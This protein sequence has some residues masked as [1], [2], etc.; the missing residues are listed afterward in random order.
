MSGFENRLERFGHPSPKRYQIILA[1]LLIQLLS[2]WT[3]SNAADG[4]SLQLQLQLR[5]RV[6]LPVGVEREDVIC[7]L[8]ERFSNRLF[9]FDVT[10]IERST[11]LRFETRS[12]GMSHR[13]AIVVRT[14]D[15]KWKGSWICRQDQ[16]LSSSKEEIVLEL[17][18]VQL[19]PVQIAYQSRP[20]PGATLL[21]DDEFYHE[22]L[23]AK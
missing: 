12:R 19:T 1:L 7:E 16:L 13:T 23:M 15:G 9:D 5:G 10:P 14:L 2:P 22:P 20:Q 21:V 4:P 18:P 8:V 6:N 11:D 17:R 3:H